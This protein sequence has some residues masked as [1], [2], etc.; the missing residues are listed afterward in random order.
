MKAKAKIIIIALAVILSA[1]LVYSA[2]ATVTLYSEYEGDGG[3]AA[4][5]DSLCRLFTD[6]FA[7][8]F[9]K[10]AYKLFGA[11]L[12]KSVSAGYDGYLFP[13]KTDGFDYTADIA[14]KMRYDD[15][16]KQKFLYSLETRREA[17]M[18][19]G[20]E[21]YV[22]VIPNS[23]T[24]LRDKLK[25]KDKNG[26]TAAKD[27][28]EYLRSNGFD[29]F[30]LL[31]DALTDKDFETYNNT[32]N[33]INGYG[34]YVVYNEICSHMP[35]GVTRRSQKLT[36][37]A[38]DISITYS[39]G[40]ALAREAGIEKLI[41]NKNVS[42]SVRDLTGTYTSELSGS[43][44]VCSLN[45]EY[46]AFIGKSEVLIQMP[47]GERALFMPLLSATY[48]DTVYNNS[49]SYS[50]SAASVI[51]PAVDVC[52]L[53]EDKLT[54]LL[55]DADIKTYE[56]HLQSSGKGG[57]T[58][59]PRI[60]AV[61][62]KQSGY[63]IVA[64][65]CEDKATVTVSSGSGSS[66]VICRNGLFIAELPAEKGGEL[67]VYAQ[68]DGKDRSDTVKCAVPV[69]VSSEENVFA[70]GFSMLYYGE[71]VSDYT[72]SNL[73]KPERLET[74]KMRFETIKEKIQN[75]SGKETKIIFLTAPDPLSVY[76]DGASEKH[77]SRRAEITRFDQFKETL[78][79]IDGVTF[80]DIRDVM[81]ENT[82]IDKLYYQTDTHWTE[83][84]A[85]FGYRAI[86]EN[87]SKDYTQISPL[88]LKSF[89]L[90]EK[91]VP[92][93]DLASFAG[94]NGVTENVTFMTPEFKSKAVGIENKPETIDRSC[95]AGELESAVND[96]ALPV[97]YMIRDS[98]SANLFP[99]ICEHFSY[100]Y[101]QRM[102]EYEPDYEKI[103]EC[104]PD[105]VIYVMSER[106]LNN[107]R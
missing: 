1:A 84:G 64:G 80:L 3:F 56:A 101:C 31:D 70:G 95:Y 24:V 75:A 83:V 40:G 87:I 99:L 10:T 57:V 21:L 94:I 104:K 58:T 26:V 42:Y 9:K 102:W 66:A 68:K 23:Q 86:I 72:G 71:T 38:N 28:E 48:T 73:L 82:D 81:R 11:V 77:K 76:T 45:D 49:L 55:D 13:T 106:N 93:G 74:V 35:N 85:Y 12:E 52:I 18:L 34:A 67:T 39:D 30:Y 78:S 5:T 103:A 65:A 98:Y 7:L 19:D 97:A 107:W 17:L 44:T 91:T 100:M 59:Q 46:N 88:S 90:T 92:S 14:G 96:A 2:A 37:G 61:S 105:Y 53:R 29:N 6:P 79:S 47:D 8:T 22:F 16:E 69:T 62:Y 41:K 60:D 32:E 15:E 27:L 4:F 43:L 33:S 63:A 36:I 89:K 50:S 25:V 54:C 20:C 51:K